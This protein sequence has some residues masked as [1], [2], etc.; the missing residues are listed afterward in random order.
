MTKKRLD[1]LLVKKKLAPT[2]SQARLL[3]KEGKVKVDNKPL[4]KP[5]ASVEEGAKIMRSENEQYVSRGAHKLKAAIKNFGLNPKD[6][7]IAD[8]GASTGGFSDYLLQSGA[9]KIY[10]IDVGHEQLSEK[11]ISDQRVVNLEGVNI[12]DGI[13]L[14]EKVD[15]AVADL[16][17]ISLRL[18]IKPM[19]E[20]LKKN[21]TM[22]L[23]FK[24]QFEVGP[25]NLNKKGVV[26]S[27][28]IRKKA[29]DEFTQ[30]CRENKFQIKGVIESPIHGKDGNKE[31]LVYL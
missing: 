9:K 26:K 10:A 3:I 11:L 15:W 4:S 20:L 30:W 17:F 7:I 2:R 22:I 16:S 8:I 27:E 25:E 14:P 12:R 21:G 19:K 23:L 28:V 31:Y 1:E 13:L 6:Q 24:P 18:T 29:L 5:G